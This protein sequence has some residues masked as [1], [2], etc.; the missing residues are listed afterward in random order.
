MRRYIVAGIAA[1]GVLSATSAVAPAAAPVASF[2]IGPPAYLYVV[3]SPLP[4]APP[5]P[6]YVSGVGFPFTSTSVDPDGD[7]LTLLWDL[8]GDGKFD[9][10]TTA[11][12][13][14]TY[15]EPGEYAVSLRVI[16]PSGET[17]TATSPLI[18]TLPGPS[19]ASP[20]A[21]SPSAASAS[22]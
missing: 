20:S 1:V 8:D 11:E 17:S 10:G 12:V 3:A 14:W 5:T 9:D 19:A 15:R 21:A 7:P 4:G 22:A 6:P 16:D 2:T 18:V 13:A